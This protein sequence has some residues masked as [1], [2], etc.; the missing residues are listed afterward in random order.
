MNKIDFDNNIDIWKYL[1]DIDDKTIDV[2]RADS[3]KTIKAVDYKYNRLVV[4]AGKPWF[5]KFISIVERLLS[6]KLSKN[7]KI[8]DEDFIMIA[9]YDGYNRVKTLPLIAGKFKYKVFFLPTITRPK[10]VRDFYNYYKNAEMDV[11]FGTFPKHVI[12]EYSVFL[13]RN[14]KAFSEIKCEDKESEKILRYLMKRFAIYSIYA[15][16]IFKHASNEKLWIF[17]QDKFYF[18]P[19]INEFRK[20]RV[21]TVELQHGTF[22]NPMIDFRLPLYVDKMICCSERERCLYRDGGVDVK[23]IY[24]T[25]APLQ[26]LH[27][28]ED[29]DGPIKYDLLVLLTEAI[30]SLI[31]KQIVTLTYINDHYKDKRILIRFRPKSALRDKEIL[32]KYVKGYS[33]STGTSLMEDLSSSERVVTLSEDSIFSIIQARKPFIAFVNKSDLY[34]GYLDGLCH[35]TDDIEECLTK[36]FSKDYSTDIDKYIY[37]FGETDINVVKNRFEKVLYELKDLKDSFNQD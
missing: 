22:F 21:M 25:G 26:T 37:A 35:T 28:K 3:I 7:Y 4:L 36:L 33:I 10:H 13:K 1:F 12:K 18:I 27:E 31:E 6:P 5:I 30:P 23:D 9:S 2:I 32:A 29:A 17:E 15:K 19:V 8:D 24:V 16:E 20:N 11:C 14:K 34:G